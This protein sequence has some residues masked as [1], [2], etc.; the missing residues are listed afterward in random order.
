MMGSRMM[1]GHMMGVPMMGWQGARGYYSNLTPEQ[2]RQRQYMT[3]QYLATQQKMMNHM[4]WHQLMMGTG[5]MR[6]PTPAPT[7]NR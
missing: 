2:V 1:G 6:Q 4:M 3:D 5:M 7:P